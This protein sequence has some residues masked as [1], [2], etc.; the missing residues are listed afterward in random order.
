MSYMKRQPHHNHSERIRRVTAH[1]FGSFEENKALPK[2]KYF[3]FSS[4]EEDPLQV[5]VPSG[6][7]QVEM[8][9]YRE[10]IRISLAFHK[11]LKQILPPSKEKPSTGRRR[12]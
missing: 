3:S 2:N 5:P 8:A 9:F 7:K 4:L 10:D 11:V 6:A 12:W 1:D